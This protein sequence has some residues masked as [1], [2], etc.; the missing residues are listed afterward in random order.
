ML[1]KDSTKVIASPE[2]HEF[3]SPFGD[4]NPQFSKPGSA[5]TTFCINQTKR[6]CA[7]TMMNTR[8]RIQ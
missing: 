2:T 3:S 1:E 7:C 6:P 5:L 4:I 8:R